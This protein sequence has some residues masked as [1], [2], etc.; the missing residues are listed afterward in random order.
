MGA[1]GLIVAGCMIVHQDEKV[2]LLALGFGETALHEQA[3]L[4]ESQG[5]GFFLNLIWRRNRNNWARETKRMCRCQAVQ[6]R[7]S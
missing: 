7:C 5:R 4:R 6:E 3:S 2:S 1:V